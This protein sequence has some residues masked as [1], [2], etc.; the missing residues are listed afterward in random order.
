MDLSSKEMLT[1][2]GRGEAIASVAAAAGLG[3]DG[4]DA[5]WRSEAAARVPPADGTRRLDGIRAEIHRDAWGIPHIHAA[6]DEA[7]FV[8]F[9]YAMAQDRLFQ[10]DYLRRKASGNLAAVLGPEG[11]ASDIVARTIGLRRIA[12]AE[13]ERLPAETRALLDAFARGINA[14]IAESR[15]RL[16]IEFDLLDCQPAPWSPGDS[17][18]G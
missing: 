18:A 11:L 6:S 16:P 13:W 12:E 17:P 5:W 3:R 2:L 1:R 8:A 14:V 10:L 15:D 4:F 7:L 9:G